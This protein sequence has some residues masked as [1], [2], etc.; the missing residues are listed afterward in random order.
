MRANILKRKLALRAK[1]KKRVRADIFGTIERPR[2]SFFN[3]IVM[4][5]HKQLMTSMALL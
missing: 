4:S 5:M 3:L 2:I 1:R